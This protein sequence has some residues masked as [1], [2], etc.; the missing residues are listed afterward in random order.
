MNNHKNITDSK[1]LSSLRKDQYLRHVGKLKEIY[2][3][4]TQNVPKA[5]NNID[6][7]HRLNS[8]KM[9]AHDYNVTQYKNKISTENKVLIDR[10]LSINRGKY[11]CAIPKIN[12]FENEI[13][14]RT[15]SLLNSNKR[16][17]L[18][19][20][21]T[22]NNKL[23]NRILFVQSSLSKEKFAKDDRR[24]E[25]YRKF[26]RRPSI[27][28]NYMKHHPSSV[29]QIKKAQIFQDLPKSYKKIKFL[30]PLN[31]TINENMHHNNDDTIKNSRSVS[32]KKKKCKR[33]TAIGSQR[34][35]SKQ[36]FKR[37]FDGTKSNFKKAQNDSTEKNTHEIQLQ[38]TN[39]CGLKPHDSILIRMLYYTDFIEKTFVFDKEGFKENLICFSVNNNIG[40]NENAKLELSMVNS[41][42][43]IL[44]TKDDEIL[45]INILPK[46]YEQS[47]QFIDGKIIRFNVNVTKKDY[48]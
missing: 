12:I 27:D 30:R 36:I 6:I 35:E 8:N 1:I 29:E 15:K 42:G 38:F 28:N 4:P 23:A 3:H 10:L 33:S 5:C 17:E 14:N 13:V 26:F 44:K 25:T 20:I 19:R 47:M 9:A 24:N 16:H 22:E 48:V 37:S 2:S 11:K 41:E 32:K 43:T 21:E 34:H 40:K 31:K 18:L 7:M 45:I 39:D 46:S